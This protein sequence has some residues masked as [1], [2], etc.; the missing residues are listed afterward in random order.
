MVAEVVGWEG[1][2][3]EVLQQMLDN[4]AKAKAA[5]VEAINE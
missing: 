2:P 4:L 3:P 5:G 1:H